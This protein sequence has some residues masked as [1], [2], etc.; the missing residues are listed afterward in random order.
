MS[1]TDIGSGVPDWANYRPAEQSG[2]ECGTCDYFVAGRCEMFDY[3]TVRD[4]YVCDRWDGSVEKEESPMSLIDLLGDIDPERIGNVAKFHGRDFSESLAKGDTNLATLHLRV[5][6]MSRTPDGSL[7]YRMVTRD[8]HYV[9]RTNPSKVRAK[10]GDILKV[11]AN[12]FLQ[13]A[14]GDYRWVNPNVVSHYTDAAHSWSELCAIAGGEIEKDGA[15]ADIPSPGDTGASSSMPSG[16]TLDSVHIPVPLSNISLFYGNKKLKYRVQKSSQHKQLIYGIVLE[17]EV[18]DSQDDF[19]FSSQV[20]RAAHTYL[21]KVARGQSS[22]SKLQHRRK[23]FFKNKPSVVPVE[24]YIAPMDFSYDGKEM[25]KK[26]S[27]VMVLHVED[28]DIWD[29]VLQG[30]F[31]GLSIG[32]TGIR[33]EMSIPPME[34]TAGIGNSQASDWFR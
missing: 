3:T 17:P 7:S 13:D 8:G 4:D 1:H 21:K 25:V 19:M 29:S 26:G 22:V 28:P 14:T 33:Q 16:P 2:I 24:S 30:E 27:W 11:Q 12:D 31:T 23:G 18:L 15:G 34:G 10:K 20:E 6:G 5:N 32:G 9:G